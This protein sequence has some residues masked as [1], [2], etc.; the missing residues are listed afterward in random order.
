MKLGTKGYVF[1]RWE[2]FS[3]KQDLLWVVGEINDFE[4]EQ[5]GGRCKFKTIYLG[6]DPFNFIKDQKLLEQGNDQ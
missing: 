2:D 1:F 4:L 6:D 5:S 3:S